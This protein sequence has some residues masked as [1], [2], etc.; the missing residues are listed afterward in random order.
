MKRLL[1]LIFPL[2]ALSFFSFVPS[3]TKKVKCMIQMSNYSGEGAYI[4]VSLINP[5]GAY[6]KTLYVFGDDDEWYYEIT[7]WW[8]F[9]GKK[10]DNLDGVTGSTISGGERGLCVLSFD[11][12]KI[13]KGYKIRFES[14]VEHQKYHEK[15]VELELTSENLA[16]KLV[17]KGFIRYVRFI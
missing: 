13:D 14:A 7:S 12:D 6:E 4:V 9:Q 1:Y 8:K 2:I 16:K 17:G 3:T 5:K 15:D 11:A 10:K